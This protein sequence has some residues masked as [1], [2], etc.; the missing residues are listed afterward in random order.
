MNRLQDLGQVFFGKSDVGHLFGNGLAILSKVAA[1]AV[2]MVCLFLLLPVLLARRRLREGKG[3]AGWDLGYVACLGMGFMFLEIA[4][5]QRFLLYLGNPTYTLVVV[6]FILLL[7]GGIGSRLFTGLARP[8]STRLALL[9]VLGGLALYALALG[10]GIG[11]ISHSTWAWVPLARAA[12]AGLMLAPLGLMLGM[13]FP[14][15]LSVIAKRAHTRIPWLWSINSA[16]SVL[17]S[18][19]ATLTSLQAGIPT[20]LV[21]GALLYGC[22]ALLWLRVSVEG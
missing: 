14:T 21:V 22:A 5:I 1:I 10:V 2:V 20:T 13:P 18:V 4:L 6:L 3:A 11:A 8:G 16:T 9:V 7:F 12:L 19:L 17:G 15:G